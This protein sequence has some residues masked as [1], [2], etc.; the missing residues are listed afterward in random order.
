MTALSPSEVEKEWGDLLRAAR[1]IIRKAGMGVKQSR[2]T[3]NPIEP[4]WDPIA[5]EQEDESDMD[6]TSFGRMY[7]DDLNLVEH[8]N[9]MEGD[10]AEFQ[11]INHITECAVLAHLILLGEREEGERAVVGKFCPFDDDQEILGWIIN[12]HEST[13]AMSESKKEKLRSLLSEWG[14]SRTEAKVR[15]LLELIGKL[16]WAS[17]AVRGGRYFVHRLIHLTVGQGR[18]KYRP[19]L[20]LR[21]PPE[22][23]HDLEYWRYAMSSEGEQEGV[24]RASIASAM[25]TRLS[26]WEF[27]SDASHQA[28]GGFGVVTRRGVFGCHTGLWWRSDLEEDQKARLVHGAKRRRKRER[29]RGQ[30]HINLLELLAM[31]VNAILMV[32]TLSLLPE[33]D[34]ECITLWCDNQTAVH[35]VANAGG[36]RTE[37]EAALIRTLGVLATRN[38]WDFVPQH[39]SGVEN[40]LAD[41]IS[42][43]TPSQIPRFLATQRPEVEWQRI[44]LPSEVVDFLSRHLAQTWSSEASIVSRSSSIWQSGV[45]SPDSATTSA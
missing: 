18:R 4:R 8:F 5:A 23:H 41:A 31:V 12:T 10:E 35:Q 36:V 11:R 45:S 37:R 42:R 9:T 1:E 3:T 2:T 13:I 20:V 32:E 14:P 26:T 34:G 28:I 25:D 24:L 30:I 7:V 27:K 17:Y 21:I 29:S 44:D 43:L 38:R 40:T 19:N 22:A 33:S 16:F 39:V 15:E 6:G